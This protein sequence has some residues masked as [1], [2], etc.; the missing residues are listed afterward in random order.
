MIQKKIPLILLCS[1][2]TLSAW[3]NA[4]SLQTALDT[5]KNQYRVKTLNEFFRKYHESDPA[6]AVGYAREALNLATEI[7]DKKGLAA[8]YNNLGIAYKTQGALDK[9][10]EYYLTSL[11]TYESLNNKEGIATTK[12]NIA[13]IYSMKKD[14]GQAMKYMEESYTLFV[15]MKDE[16]KI[17]RSMNNLGNLH[18]EIQLY[19]KA[20]SYF[21]QAY[22]LSEKKGTV[23]ADPLTNMG[24]LYFRQNNY[25]RAVEHYE[26]AL[27]LERESNNKLAALNII[28]N[29]GITYTKAKQPKPAQ[30]YLDE[31]LLL[32]NELQAFSFHP[33]I[34][35]TI[36]ENY[37]T[38]GKW[39]EA[40]DAQ[41]KYD[42][43]REKIYG[44]ES[45]RNI[46][47]M[48]MIMEFQ[49]K[50]KEYDLLK[51]QDEITKLELRNSRLFIVLFILGGLIILGGLNF[52]YRKKRVRRM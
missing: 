24:N 10:L 3:A 48:E 12:S 28:V 51:Q 15:E 39:K 45:S 37:S 49:Q 41:L 17:I 14:Y 32:C 16:D 5:A 42:E 7:N 44:E 33:T 50:D 22:Q 27:E 13:T 40:Y 46:A 20:M 43:T 11:R 25:Q 38:Q 34:Y 8:A 26:K 9:A 2:I 4:D 31:S 6:K 47:Q 23:Y 18:S 36:A 30:V 35:K 29:L 52:F 21:S 1:V 19:E